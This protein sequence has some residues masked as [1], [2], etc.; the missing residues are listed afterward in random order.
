MVDRWTKRRGSPLI[1]ALYLMPQVVCRQWA[2]P[3]WNRNLTYHRQDRSDWIHFVCLSLESVSLPE[4]P[5]PSSPIQLASIS[6]RVRSQKR[7]ATSIAVRPICNTF[8]A[9][10]WIIVSATNYFNPYERLTAICT[11][12]SPR[13]ICSSERS[14]LQGTSVNLQRWTDIQTRW[15]NT[16]R[17]PWWLPL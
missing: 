7:M 14:Y 5:G 6:T 10:I 15:S 2:S 17:T 3:T 12:Q 1:L 11:T 9:S 13:R 8:Q 16:F 4:V